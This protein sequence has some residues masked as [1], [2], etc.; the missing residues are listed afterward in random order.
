MRLADALIL[1]TA[2]VLDADHIL[3]GDHR[4]TAWS[5][6]VILAVARAI[7]ESCRVSDVVA[8][9]GGDEFVVVGLGPSE[10]V[11]ELERR[12]RTFL[13]A[14]YG[15]DPTLSALTISVGRAELAPWEDGDPEQLLWRADHDMYQRRGG[16]ADSGRRVFLPDGVAPFEM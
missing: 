11:D 7:E 2:E 16:R 10:P 9:W 5:D 13:A 8:R 12:V 1:G 14:H 4:W 3:T 15:S 6:R